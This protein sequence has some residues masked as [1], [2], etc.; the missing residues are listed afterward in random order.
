VAVTQR[1]VRSRGDLDRTLFGGAFEDR[2]ER[3][4][5]LGGVA[6]FLLGALIGFAAAGSEI[7]VPVG[8]SLAGLVLGAG[9]GALASLRRPERP[10]PRAPSPRTSTA[11][12]TLDRA[13]APAEADGDWLVPPDWYPDPGG[14]TSRRYWDGTDWTEHLWAAGAK[15][16]PEIP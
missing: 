10:A 11:G 12:R 3:T 2:V 13:T 7:G 8:M 5:P 1:T 14:S 16:P 9:A 6:G 15:S 4:L